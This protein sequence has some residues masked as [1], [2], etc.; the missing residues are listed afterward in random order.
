[1]VVAVVSGQAVVAS[2]GNYSFTVDLVDGDQLNP[3]QPDGYAIT[4]LNSSGLVW[5]QIGSRTALAPLGGGNTA[6]HSK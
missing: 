5:R 1:M 2:Y 4:V 6:V 3:R